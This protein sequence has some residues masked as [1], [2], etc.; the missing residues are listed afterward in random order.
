MKVPETLNEWKDQNGIKLS[1]GL[2][3]I[4][5]NKILLLG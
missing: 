3:V 1:A 2:V 4:Q 5:D